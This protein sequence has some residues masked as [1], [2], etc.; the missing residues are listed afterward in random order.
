MQYISEIIYFNL[1][2]IK[3]IPPYIIKKQLSWKEKNRLEV[4]LYVRKSKL[5][6]KGESIK[7][8]IDMCREYILQRYPD[9]VFTIYQDEGYSG[10]NLKRPGF[11]HMIEDI[12]QKKADIVVCY[13]LD[14]IS[15]SVS[16]FSGILDILNEKNIAFVSVKEHFDTSTPIGRAMMYISS[17]FAQLER[18]TIAERIQDNMR[19][20]ARTGRWLGGTTPTGF[21]C[22]KMEYLDENKNKK[23]LCHLVPIKS[24]VQLVKLI[25]EKYI[26]FESQSALIAYTLQN[27]IKTKTGADFCTRTV[28]N[29]LSN[30]VYVI[31]DESI[32]KYYTSLGCDLVNDSSQYKGNGLMLTNRYDQT[33][34]KKT[35]ERDKK[36]WVITIGAHKGIIDSHT[37]LKAQ[38]LLKENE[39]KP[40]RIYSSSI[41]LVSSSIICPY[42]GS[43]MIV[44]HR[45][46]SNDS[47]KHYYY[48]CKTKSNS[49][50]T[51]CAMENLQGKL[52]DKLILDE[53]IQL[54]AVN[55]K[56]LIKK[57][58][59]EQMILCN[60]RK[61]EK[62][63]K[64]LI[65]TIHQTE[66]KIKIL[67]SHLSD[68]VSPTIS[69]YIIEQIEVYDTVI[70]QANEALN[71]IENNILQVSDYKKFN[72]FTT[73]INSFTFEEKKYY[74]KEL[75][76]RIEIENDELKIILKS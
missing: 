51:L 62:E 40:P 71:T 37:F 26:T 42:C 74:V 18:E 61:K 38:K 48:K 4:Y 3:R 29:I 19:K 56:E 12:K 68:T 59:A 58:E 57:L 70:K 49:K 5:S 63:K 67:I 23:K 73:D 75:V 72:D 36:E 34:K 21:R 65:Q 22:E 46:C 13:K 17:V 7:N 39:L 2:Y 9:A 11:Y 20:L 1:S 53:L 16:D 41:A 25:F 33:N 47:I 44:T 52:T 45:G 76:E 24:E 64:Q 8:Q 54:S 31:S 27:N 6:K 30:P 66:K 32:Y 43:K 55:E 28:K 35:M 14:R 69:K 50:G 10:K 15:R 60:K